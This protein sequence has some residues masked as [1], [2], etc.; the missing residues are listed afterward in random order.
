MDAWASEVRRRSRSSDS[1]SSAPTARRRP[2][3]HASLLNDSSCC[4]TSLRLRHSGVVPFSFV[5]P[6]VKRVGEDDVAHHAPERI[7][8]AEINRG[9]ELEIS[10]DVAGKADGG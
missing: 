7:F 6:D 2:L 8:V 3:R 5:A 4:F 1:I 9:I 10:S